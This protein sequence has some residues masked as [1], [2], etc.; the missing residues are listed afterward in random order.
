TFVEEIAGAAAASGREVEVWAQAAPHIVEK[1]WQFNLRRLPLTGSHDLTCQLKLARA[2]IAGRRHLRHATVYLAEP[3]PM[4]TW[5]WLQHC[6]AFR[7]KHL[8]LTFHGSEILKFHRNPFMRPLARRLIKHA[9]RIST[10]TEYTRNLLISRFPVANGKTI[11]TPG[12]LRTNFHD[13]STAPIKPTDRLVILTVGRLHPR[14]GQ[15]QTLAALA[16]LPVEERTGIEYWVVGPAPHNHY[17]DELRQRAGAAEI[18]VKFL[19]DLPD[20]QL[21]AT[22]DQADIFALTSIAYGSSIEGFGL[23]Y[24]EASAHGL[25]VIAHAIG[26]VSE[27]VVDGETGLLV[28]PDQPGALTQAFSRLIADAELRHRLGTAGREWARRNSWSRS[29]ALLFGPVNA[30][31]AP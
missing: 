11:L 25:P 2:I 3:G 8:L 28:S 14:K 26:G 20:D 24:L 23:V 22:Y 5:M 1:P 4:L 9:E 29:A 13:T 27:A 17:H 6:H 18:P 12:A 19:G 10:L 31:S 21:G 7:P 15:L 16:A 30:D